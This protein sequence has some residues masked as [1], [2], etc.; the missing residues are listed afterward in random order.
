MKT[1]QELLEPMDLPIERKKVRDIGDVGWLLRNMGIRNKDH[2]NHD[3]AL[4]M[5]KERMRDEASRTTNSR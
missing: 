1:L 4:H 5:L 3:A 2:P